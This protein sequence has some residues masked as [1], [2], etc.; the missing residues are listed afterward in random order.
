MEKSNNDDVGSL[1][2]S[3]V[4]TL[5]DILG[6]VRVFFDI[7]GLLDGLR[8]STPFGNLGLLANLW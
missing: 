8:M 1:G 7:R 5:S 6:A 3:A 2:D 4:V